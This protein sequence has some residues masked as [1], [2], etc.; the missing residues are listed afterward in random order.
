M[1]R[2][3]ITLVQEKKLTGKIPREAIVMTEIPRLPNEILTGFSNLADLAGTVSDA[4]DELGIIGVVPASVLK[5]TI[6]NSR[7]VGPAVTVRNI[8]QNTQAYKGAKERI[9]KMAEIEGHNLSQP[10]DV[11]VIEGLDNISNMGGISASIG[12]RQ[13]EAGAIVEG[14]I[15]DVD[16]SRSIGFP[17]WSRGISP[18]T[19]KWR[20]GSSR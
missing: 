4:M 6:P 18:I 20:F 11:L 5:P 9:S 15:R 16:H 3:E 10:G 8:P 17:I 7:L 19:G 12:K 1:I 2:G 13:G 14:A